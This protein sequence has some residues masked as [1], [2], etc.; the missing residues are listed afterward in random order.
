MH[1][2]TTHLS[3]AAP[4]MFPNCWVWSQ[5]AF[6]EKFHSAI[7]YMPNT[8]EILSSQDAA[9]IPHSH[10]RFGEGLWILFR[11]VNGVHRPAWLLGRNTSLRLSSPAH[12]PRAGPDKKFKEI[13]EKRNF[14]AAGALLGFEPYSSIPGSVGAV[15]AIYGIQLL[16]EALH[17]PQH[18]F[19]VNRF[20]KIR[21]M[22]LELW[23]AIKADGTV[24]L[25][26]KIFSSFHLW[27]IAV[28]LSY[29]ILYTSTENIFKRRLTK[30]RPTLR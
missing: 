29:G 30:D 22:H 8:E 18:G 10:T 27:K 11:T 4:A 6:G 23:Y 14:P 16:T 3:K 5:E 7:R 12:T 1:H 28:S 21:R 15:R 9:S 24:L 2:R 20:H 26:T 17:G 13:E 25:F 19:Y